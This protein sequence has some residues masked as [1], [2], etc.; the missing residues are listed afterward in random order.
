MNVVLGLAILTAASTLIRL[1][2]RHFSLWVDEGMSVGIASHSLTEIPGVLI[3]DGSPPLYYL[4]LHVWMELF[5]SSEGAVRALSLVFAV[6]AIPVG[7]WAGRSRFGR[8]AGWVAALLV[9]FSSYLTVHS[10]EARMY[11]LVVLL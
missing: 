4:L 8:R 1:G 9:A 7:G 10:R 11:S 5:G 6:A 3:N 2:G